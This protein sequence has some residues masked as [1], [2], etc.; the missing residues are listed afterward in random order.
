MFYMM[1][2]II[3]YYN[4]HNFKQTLITDYFKKNDQIIYIPINDEIIEAISEPIVYGFNDKT[5]SWH[6]L[7][8]G[9]DMGPSNPRQLCGKTRCLQWY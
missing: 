3:I 9:A 7:E 1:Q 2:K 8:C 6:C 4:T 5:N